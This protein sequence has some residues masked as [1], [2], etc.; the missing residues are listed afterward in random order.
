VKAILD[1]ARHAARTARPRMI[2]V[3]GWLAF[4]TYA[5]PGYMSYDSVYQLLE[6]RS[7]ELGTAHP[8]MMGWLWMLVDSVIAGPFGMLLIQSVC[9]LAGGYLLLVRYMTPRAAAVCACVLLLLPPVSAVMAVI[10]KDS[11]M[12]AFLLLGTALLLSPRRAIRVLALVMIMIASGMRHNALSL[13]FAIVVLLFTWSPSLRWYKRYP[14][15]IAAW[16]LVTFSAQQLQTVLTVPSKQEGASLWY[17]LALLDIVGTIRHSSE[18]SDAELREL[19]AGTPLLHEDHLQE[20][21][22]R[23]YRIEDIEEKTRFAL[24]TGNYITPLWTTTYNFFAVAENNEQV[25]AIRRAWKEVIVAHPLAYL[26][27][28][29]HVFADR[30]QLHGDPIPSAAYV[31]FTDV[32]DPATSATKMGHSALPS[33]I[34]DTLRECMHWL[35]TT[36]L[37][38]PYLYLAFIMVLLPLWVRERLLLALAGSA[39]GGEAALFVVAPTNDYRYSYWT[40]IAGI[41]I[42]MITIAKRAQRVE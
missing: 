35:G 37:F 41:L 28:R 13:T 3:V 8:P 1:R 7:G 6:A 4:M 27:Y 29:W 38:R 23:R 18:M 26:E 22:R 34:Q 40:V 16:V 12:A 10:W 33:R 14:I 31:W 21:T 32:I 20:A 9:F 24:G 36:E 25:A 30:V 11:Q 2:L 19:L 42:V 39:L 17:G 15:A 5:Y